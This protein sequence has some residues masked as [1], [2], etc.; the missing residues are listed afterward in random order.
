MTCRPAVAFALAAAAA[1]LLSCLTGCQATGPGS[2]ARPAA[3]ADVAAWTLDAIRAVGSPAPAA[4]TKLSGFETCRTDTGYFAT[5]TQWRTITD[6]AVPLARQAAATSAIETAFTAKG[7]HTAR[8]SGLVTMAGPSGERRKGLIKIQTAG[9]SELE[10]AVM[11]PCY[12]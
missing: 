5:S 6:V 2:F 12:K 3:Q 1:V 8:S 9:S 4:T 7:W 10:V 11:S